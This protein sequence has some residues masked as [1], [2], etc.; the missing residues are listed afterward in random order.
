M[1][2]DGG[3]VDEVSVPSWPCSLKVRLVLMLML[4]MMMSMSILVYDDDVDVDLVVVT[5]DGSNLAG[6]RCR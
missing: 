4:V 3:I 6:S 2:D 1:V 5:L